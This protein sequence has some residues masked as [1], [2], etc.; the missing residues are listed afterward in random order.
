MASLVEGRHDDGSRARTVAIIGLFV[1]ACF[2]ALYFASEFFV[3]VVA[4]CLLSLVLAPAAATLRRL[5]LPAP[6]AALIVV[7]AVVTVISLA[8]VRLVEP[9]AT[10]VQ[11]GPSAYYELRDKLLPVQR[12]VQQ[13]QKAA[14]NV[15]KA[16]ELSG[17]G[18]NPPLVV[19]VKEK[20]LLAGVLDRAQRTG[21]GLLVCVVLT[22]FLLASGDLFREK[23]VGILPRLQQKREAMAMSREILRDVSN[24][25]FSITLINFGLGATVATGLYF[26]GMPN[27]VLWGV[28][29]AMLNFIPYFGLAVGLAIVFLV[30]LTHFDTLWGAAMAPAI[31]LAANGIEN[32]FITPSL[33]GRRLELNPPVI[34]VWVVFW[35]WF[36][37]IAGGLMAVPILIVLKSVC[38]HCGPL[39]ALGEFLNGRSPKKAAARPAPSQMVEIG[40]DR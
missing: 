21:V 1:L 11:Q 31:Y 40:G 27:P 2:A 12:Q 35:S 17:G 10:W 9:A 16:T 37:G 33:L 25:L 3:P 13:V 32:Q 26:I 36:W 7:A 8:F 5:H 4:G 30:A 15:E 28:M 23:L 24:Y 38:N 39:A 18:P 29:V 6:I 22:F 34:F 14:K 20:G 19:S